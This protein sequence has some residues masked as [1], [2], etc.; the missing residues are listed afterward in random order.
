MIQKFESALH[1]EALNNL[2]FSFYSTPIF[3]DF[4]AYTFQRNNEDLVV[5]QDIIFPHDFPA[6]FLPKDKKNWERCSI[7]FARKE[8][9]DAIR[10]EGI[11]IL[12]E[13]P[14]QREYF[15]ATESFVN[16]TGSFKK[17]VNS[18]K[19]KYEY[20]VRSTCEREAILQFYIFWKNQRVHTGITFGDAEDFFFYCLDRRE[21]LKQVYVFIGEQ[22]V[23][24]AWGVEHPQ[25]G[26][27]GLQNKVHY[28][29]QGLSRFLHHERAKLFAHIPEFALGGGG[30]EKGIDAFKQQL[31]P[32]REIVYSY[33]L[34]DGKKSR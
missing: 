13:N 9:I 7:T 2:P 1:G 27:V 18:F 34:T 4:E 12:V 30:F 15:F 19:K 28:E 3:L 10:E 20:T 6:F 17:H 5:M 22:L 21:E 14:G 25:G 8:D 31:N 26:W 16:P 11:P 29:Y 32:S 24:F 23:G 33:V